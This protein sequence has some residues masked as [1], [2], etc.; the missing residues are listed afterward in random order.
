MKP[1]YFPNSSDSDLMIFSGTFLLK[2]LHLHLPE[3]II[4]AQI[5][6][7]IGRNYS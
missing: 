4:K 6:K 3:F 1:F 5:M 7:S 2:E